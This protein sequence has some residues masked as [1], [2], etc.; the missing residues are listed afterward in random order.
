MEPVDYTLSTFILS[1]YGHH[2]YADDT[3]FSLL[4]SLRLSSKHLAPP[5]CSHTYHFLNDF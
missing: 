2:L 3:T 4:S 1:L 5:E